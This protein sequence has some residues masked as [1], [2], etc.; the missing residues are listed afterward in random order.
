MTLKSSGEASV[1]VLASVDRLWAYRESVAIAG[2]GTN[3]DHVPSSGF[4]VL[5][6]RTSLSS[7][8]PM[9]V[10]FS[11]SKLSQSSGSPVPKIRE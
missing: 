7:V 3:G 10:F 8:V 11:E 9:G 5:P 4:V 1:L 2:P 6:V